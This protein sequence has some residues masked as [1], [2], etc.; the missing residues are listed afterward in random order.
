MK[1]SK[2]LNVLLRIVNRT[3]IIYEKENV[4]CQYVLFIE[5]KNKNNFEK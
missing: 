2:N 4:L 5:A 1:K 3:I